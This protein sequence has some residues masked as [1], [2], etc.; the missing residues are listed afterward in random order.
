MEDTKIYIKNAFL[1]TPVGT[2]TFTE[3]SLNQ[4][5]LPGVKMWTY[6]NGVW[7]YIQ[8]KDVTIRT[9]IVNVTFA[10]DMSKEEVALLEKKKK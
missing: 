2:P 10:V 4:S 8:Y 9:P 3:S 7:F 5:K 1:Q 6:E